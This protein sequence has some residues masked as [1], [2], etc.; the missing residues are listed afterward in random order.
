MF[1]GITLERSR[2]RQ[3]PTNVLT[4]VEQTL[5]R[6]VAVRGRGRLVTDRRG[7][8]IRS[9][10][11]VPQSI[12]LLFSLRYLRSGLSSSNLKFARFLYCAC[13]VST[14]GSLAPIC[15]NLPHPLTAGVVDCHRRRRSQSVQCRKS[16][17]AGCLGRH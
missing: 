15:D 3:I 1:R 10:P 9:V 8:A 16:E 11:L 7:V 2:F 17:P 13:S 5:H 12:A 6:W 4:F 14:P